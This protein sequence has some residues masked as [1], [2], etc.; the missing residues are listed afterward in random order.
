M[1]IIMILR[2]NLMIII[3]IGVF[4]MIIHLLLIVELGIVPGGGVAL[5]WASR[6]LNDIK[7]KCENMDQKIGGVCIYIYMYMY[8]YVCMY[9]YV[10]TYRCIFIY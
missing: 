6:Q 2:L 1:I 4:L 9:I 3:C 5:L 8:M 10:F 7:L